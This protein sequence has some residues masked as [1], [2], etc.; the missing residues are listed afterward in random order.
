[1]SERVRPREIGKKQIKPKLA[2][3]LMRVR[4]RLIVE[5]LP[6]VTYMYIKCV[7]ADSESMIDV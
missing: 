4:G 3:N 6:R 2:Q 1:M 5:Y 7:Y